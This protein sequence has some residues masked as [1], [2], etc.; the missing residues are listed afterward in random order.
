MF[1]AGHILTLKRARELGDYLLVGVYNDGVL[2]HYRGSNHPILNLNER[3]LS[4][5]ACKYV[6]D[7]L[8]DPPWKITAEMIA[9]LNI[10]VVV[11]GTTVENRGTK[12]EED[13]VWRGAVEAGI[14]Q[15]VESQSDLTVDKIMDRVRENHERLE[16][17]VKK[18]MKAEA[19]HYKK[20][21]G[22][23]EYPEHASSS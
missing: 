1:H 23:H 14:F 18:K 2:N 20:K 8:I 6:D 15:E 12:Q 17:K 3:V 21:H 7:V 19:E 11:T 16:K 5:L 22:L 10:S 13:S 9:A 4:V